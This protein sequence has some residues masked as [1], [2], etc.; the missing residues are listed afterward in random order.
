[1]ENKVTHFTI[2]RQPKEKD[3]LSFY[4]EVDEW[5]M[6]QLLPLHYTSLE[7]PTKYVLLPNSKWHNEAK[8][9]IKWI[10]KVYEMVDK[11]ERNLKNLPKLSL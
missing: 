10:N 7:E 9:V 3:I 2:E 8:E 4:K 5:I 11:G 6:E 1:M